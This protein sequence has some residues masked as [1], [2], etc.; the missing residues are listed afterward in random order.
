MRQ[1]MPPPILE[2][3][4]QALIRQLDMHR[5]QEAQSHDAACRAE[6]MLQLLAQ[7]SQEAAKAAKTPAPAKEE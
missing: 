7:Q 4:R 3:Q 5:K 6:G 1:T 2:T